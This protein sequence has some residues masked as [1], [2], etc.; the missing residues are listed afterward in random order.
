MASDWI[1]ETFGCLAEPEVSFSVF[2][3]TF[4]IQVNGPQHIVKLPEFNT[5]QDQLRHV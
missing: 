3:G 2:I 5:I 4:G 1:R